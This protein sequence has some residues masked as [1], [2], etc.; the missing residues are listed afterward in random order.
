[1]SDKVFKRQMEKFGTEAYQI[2]EPDPLSKSRKRQQ[3]SFDATIDIMKALM[4]T[5]EGRQWVY[6]KLDFY[7]V[8]ST[9][10]V[11]NDSHATA[12]LCGLQEAGHH[13]LH[14]IMIA[15]ANEY[16]IMLQEAAART[17]NTSEVKTE[18]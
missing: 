10:Y 3:A 16:P 11:P 13:L 15:A 18:N 5:M 4:S 9:P 6:N 1:M 12:F 7:C 17:Q 2:T 8:H 14:E